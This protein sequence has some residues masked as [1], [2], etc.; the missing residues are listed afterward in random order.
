MKVETKLIHE[1]QQIDPSTGS[2]TAPIHLSTTFERQADGSYPLGFEYS[3]GGNPN[4]NALEANLAALEKGVDAMAFSSGSVAMM[5]V[6]QALKAGDHVIAP[7]E[8]YFG[9]RVMLQDIFAPWG[10]EVSFVDMNDLGKVA[11]AMQS[12]TRLLIVES[13]SNPQLSVADLQG[14]S[15]I[16]HKQG[17]YLICD[18]TIP[19]PIL[20]RPIEWDVDMVVHAT[21]KYIGGHSD[22]LGGALITASDTDFWQ[23]IKHIQKIGGAVPSP[24]ECWL[25]SRGMQ[26]LSYRVKAMSAHAL[27]LANFL[28][29][30]PRIEQVLYPG[31]PSHPQHALAQKQMD[32]YGGLISILVKG[33]EEA[34][35]GVA[36]K[37]KVFTRATSF[38]G[39]HSLI[40]HRASVEAEGSKTPRNLLRLS[41]GLEHLDDLKADLEQAL[42]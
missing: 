13:P 6:L 39:T 7:E 31:L 29:T 35:I 18:N 23:R 2:V 14:L 9:V 8:I 16:A 25:T 36:A 40:E 28:E 34:A 41:I 1:G 5:S 11:E 30:H 37:V 21:T 3:R 38:G 19:T 32:A 17:A 33:G 42:A 26:T 12:N 15:E 20:Q 22:V 24:F 4:R 27:E 10:L